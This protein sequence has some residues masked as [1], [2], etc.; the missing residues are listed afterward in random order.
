V[1]LVKYGIA[2]LK[3]A[4]K[5]QKDCLNLHL[6][7]PPVI[8]W[9]YELRDEKDIPIEKGIGKANSFTR[10]ALNSIAYHAGLIDYSIASSTVFA[11]GLISVKITTGTVYSA[12]YTNNRFRTA[13]NNPIVLI[14]ESDEPENLD[15]YD[16][17]L[18]DV[19]AGNTT[20][21]TAFDSIERKLTTQISRAFINTSSNTHV[22]TEAGV[23]LQGYN[24]A[25]LYI[26]DVLD[27]PLTMEPNY[28]IAWTY[29]VEVLYPA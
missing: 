14:G 17:V 19:T 3:K 9:E 10:N 25:V 16:I 22:I 4:R 2:E 23:S 21:V 5:L 8:H 13:N 27:T 15:S 7:C 6:A 26:R 1:K 20:T 18:S 24:G 11:D 28:S 29:Y 12:S